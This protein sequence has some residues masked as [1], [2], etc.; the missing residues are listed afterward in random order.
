MSKVYDLTATLKTGKNLDVSPSGD[1]RGY[2]STN[3]GSSDLGKVGRES[4]PIFWATNMLFDSAT[5]NTLRNKTI[6]SVTVDIRID[7]SADAPGLVAWKYNSTSSGNSNSQ[8]WA[9][10]DNAGNYTAGDS[11]IATTSNPSFAEHGITVG[12]HTLTLK[13]LPQYGLVAGPY[14]A[15]RNGVWKIGLATLHVTTN[16]TDYTLSYNANGGTG[17]PASETKAGVGSYTFTISST[18]PSYTGYDFLG[19]S[20][21]NTATSASYQPG[22]TITVTANTT[23]YA[24]WKKKTYTISYNA[25]GGSGAP[26]SQ[27]KTY[28][29]TLKLTT[30]KPSR[31]NASAGSYTVTFNANSGSVTP[32]SASAARTTSYSF[33]NWNTAAN[34]SGTSYASGA[35]YTANAAATLYAQ[36]TSSTTTAAVTLPTPGRTGYTFN[37]WYTQASGGTRVGGAG[38]SYTPTGNV[39]LFAQWTIITYTV[40]YNT[41]GGSG[42]FAAQTKNYGGSFTIHSGSPTPPSATSAGSY[43]VTYNANG[44]SVSPSSVSAARTTNYAFSKWNTAQNGSGTNYSPGGTYSANANA[45]LYAQYTS[46]TT[47]A[48]VSLTSNVSKSGY[49]FNGWYTAASGG[50]RVGGGGSSYTPTGNVTLYAQWTASSATL[51][52][53]SP[54][55]VDCGNNL[56]GSW[57]STGST[58]KYKLKVT[59]GNATAT[60]SS[61]TAAN[62]SSTTVQI[63]TSWYSMDASLNGPLRDT[64]SA[65]A[66][67]ELY[68]YASD[69]TTQIGTASSKTFTVKVPT[70][71]VPSLSTLTASS[72]SDN[73][74]VSGWGSTVFVQGYSKVTLTQSVSSYYGS[75]FSSVRYSGLGLD[76]TKTGSLASSD[77]SSVINSAGTF[78]YTATVTDTRGRSASKTVSVTFQPYAQ[79]SVA[80]IAVQRCDSDGTVNN[81]AGAYFKATPVYSFSSVS[82][83]NAL[84]TQNIKYRVHPNGAW[85]TAIS[86]ASGSTYGPWSA[87]LTNSYDVM[88]TLADRIQNGSSQTTTFTTTLPTVQGVWIGKGNDRLGLGGV[89]PSAGLHCD[90]DATFNGVLDVTQRRCYGTLPTTGNGDG[91]YRVMQFTALNENAAN[92][93]VSFVIDFTIFRQY[94]NNNNETHK[95]TLMAS[96]NNF[97][98][99]NELSHS[100]SCVV[101]GIRYARNGSVGYV[102]IHY[103]VSTSNVCYVDFSVHFDPTLQYRFKAITPVK[104]ADSPVSPETVVTEYS[105][106]NQYGNGG[107]LRILT[108]SNN[109]NDLTREKDAGLYMLASSV[110]NAPISWAAL[111]NISAGSYGAHQFVFNH[112]SA[113]QRSYTG[114]PLAWTAWTKTI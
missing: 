102:D 54:T 24:V 108:S 76:S 14:N 6:Q 112:N 84:V 72:S 98:F 63:P 16:E 67:C 21:S 20:T 51:S 32:T 65:T 36:W 30:S 62:A 12:T 70:S 88:V 22:G 66:T 34:G 77:P 79:P 73:T 9:R 85:S 41:N 50:T 19:W 52:S 40:N 44:G 55:T 23:L 86:C 93:A 13:G 33:N 107:L 105:F 91:W 68:T 92:A 96:Y 3:V 25:N 57:T 28:G 83:K 75:R 17:A 94:N 101:D 74:V 110:Q 43:T 7:T 106:S 69:G 37:G 90:W 78:T 39:T 111:L 99:V 8:A 58:Y 1:W 109:L 97:A 35:N 49:S 42:S 64:T 81:A 71:V 18:V 46:S 27:T 114:T 95:I 61:L 2:D 103:G 104:T 60:W 31:A 11:S 48:A 4:G 15:S 38:A 59:C 26:G 89:P 82:S 80:G 45:T 53:V 29:E 5:L 100:N 47:T 10:S 56:T 113:Y 87:A